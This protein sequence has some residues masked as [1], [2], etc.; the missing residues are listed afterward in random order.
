[1]LA[2]GVDGQNIDRI[3][4]FELEAVSN[5]GVVNQ[6]PF[7]ATDGNI[8]AM[9]YKSSG[10]TRTIT[11]KTFSDLRHYNVYWYVEYTVK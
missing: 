1:M 5:D 6:I 2:L 3:K 9:W 4:V 10:S 11:L 7:H 8:S